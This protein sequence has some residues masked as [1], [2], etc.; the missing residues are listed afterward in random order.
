MMDGKKLLAGLLVCSIALA[1]TGAVKVRRWGVPFFATVAPGQG[2]IY[3][4]TGKNSG[5]V[6]YTGRVW[7][8]INDVTSGYETEASPSDVQLYKVDGTEKKCSNQGRLCYFPSESGT[9]LNP[10]DEIKGK[11]K[12]V[13]GAGCSTGKTFRL[14]CA[15]DYRTASGAWVVVSG[16]GTTEDISVASPYGDTTIKLVQLLFFLGG[17]AAL[18]AGLALVI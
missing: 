8:V 7:C 14:K 18:L 9:T 3:Q 6:T 15:M 16:S 2:A 12:V 11:I 5:S 4:I 17:G 1:A 10:G 13:I